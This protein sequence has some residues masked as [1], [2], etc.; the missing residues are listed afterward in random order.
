MIIILNGKSEYDKAL[1]RKGTLI[2]QRDALEAQGIEQLE[3]EYNDAMVR[4]ASIV[5]AD[6][7][8]FNY[9]EKWN[10]ILSYLETES[11]KNISVSSITST[12]TDLTMN[13]VVSNKD[14]AAKLLLQFQNI[15]YFSNIS[16]NGITESID[17]QTG[18]S[19]V[20]FSLKCDYKLPDS[21]N[22]GN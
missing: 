5:A 2:G 4:Y 14:E 10:D 16:I 15:P 9:N 17:D 12:P 3:T 1:E 6:L 11:V 19:T 13:I 8:T 20:S 22:A 7:G 18:V 21:E